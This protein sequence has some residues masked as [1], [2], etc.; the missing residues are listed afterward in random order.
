MSYAKVFTQIFAFT[1]KMTTH[2]CKYFDFY[3]L[4]CE[5]STR[6]C[7]NVVVRKRWEGQW[8]MLHSKRTEDWLSLSTRSNSIAA[9]VLASM[10]SGGAILWWFQQPFYVLSFYVIVYLDMIGNK[11]SHLASV[12]FQVLAWPWDESAISMGHVWCWNPKC[13]NCKS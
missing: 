7:V 6:Q 3:K 9:R 8:K 11:N 13:A 4:F 10:H 12:T 2:R 1:D 5:N